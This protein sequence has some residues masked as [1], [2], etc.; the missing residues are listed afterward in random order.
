MTEYS[1]RRPQ[2]SE[3][4]LEEENDVMCVDVPAS[5]S[6][7]EPVAVAPVPEEFPRSRSSRR[8]SP[9][10]TSNIDPDPFR[11][12][13]SAKSLRNVPS[14]R[15]VLNQWAAAIRRGNVPVATDEEWNAGVVK[16]FREL[17]ESSRRIE[18]QLN[19]RP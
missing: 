2:R 5:S 13:P 8:R 1:Y 3:A 17:E 14:L 12:P 19:V 11:I 7:P 18:G 16:S 9:R 4:S 10:Q 6:E 15:A